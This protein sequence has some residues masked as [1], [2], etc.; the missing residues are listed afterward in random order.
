MKS[1]YWVIALACAG[2][3]GLASCQLLLPD[4]P[5]TGGSSTSDGGAGM[6]SSRSS[7]GSTSANSSTG[8]SASSSTTSGASTS[9][10]SDT[11]KPG[12]PA[13]T[14]AT[15]FAGCEGSAV[16]GNNPAC[17]EYCTFVSGCDSGGM[18]QYAST[19]QCC[20]VCGLLPTLTK[21]TLCCRA[22]ALGA[23]LTHSSC[24]LGGPFGTLSDIDAE[25]GTQQNHVCSLLWKV[26]PNTSLTCTEQIC[27]GHFATVGFTTSYSYGNGAPGSI[28]EFMDKTLDAIGNAS[29]CAQ[30][31]ALACPS[32]NPLGSA[33]SSTATGI[34]P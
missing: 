7:T 11:C 32:V 15:A 2:A 14:E 26:C 19:D 8:K 6:S 25:C 18:Q 31:F 21:D 13:C 10:G 17:G 20:A 22:S 24:T 12:G 5:G 1:A 30:A 33:T 16:C 28:D 4:G 23:G 9:T 3:L 27:E 34:M 29:A